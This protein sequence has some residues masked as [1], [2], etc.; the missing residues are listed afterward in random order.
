[1]LKQVTGKVNYGWGRVIIPV[2]I[3]PYRM[4]KRGFTGGKRLLSEKEKSLQF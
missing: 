4:T 3:D 1:M 2:S